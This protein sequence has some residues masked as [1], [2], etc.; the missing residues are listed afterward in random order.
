MNEYRIAFVEK[1]DNFYVIGDKSKVSEVL[2][3]KVLNYAIGEVTHQT[4]ETQLGTSFDRSFNLVKDG[5]ITNQKKG[6]IVG[7]IWFSIT[8]K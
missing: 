5:L 7:D 6:C 3:F 8:N 1:G 2:F 4:K